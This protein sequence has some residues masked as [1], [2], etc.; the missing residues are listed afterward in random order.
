MS[1]PIQTFR[2]YKSECSLYGA[3]EDFF[4]DNRQFG[5]F[6]GE[7]EKWLKHQ[8]LFV[9][10]YPEQ[11]TKALFDMCLPAN[12][13][14]FYVSI[15]ERSAKVNHLVSLYPNGFFETVRDDGQVACFLP[16]P[17]NRA[18]FRLSFYR[19]NGPT[20]HEVYTTRTDALEHLA[21]RGFKA[22][23]GAL[24]KLVGTV[25]WDR[26]VLITQWLADGIYPMDAI[27]QSVHIPE[28]QRL[29]AND[30]ARLT[31]QCEV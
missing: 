31:E 15:F 18:K 14:G 5:C 8:R 4:L 2:E 16:E 1:H 3:S 29:F 25:L 10:R 12:K 6:E 7:F 26:G 23:E 24:D 19:E 30:I 21:R 11:S 13:W 20:Y 9:K 22:S 27:K 28:I 17:S